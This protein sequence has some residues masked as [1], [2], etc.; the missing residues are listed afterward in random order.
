[1]IHGRLKVSE[2]PNDHGRLRVN[3]LT[4]GMKRGLHRIKKHSCRCMLACC[5]M[6]EP[7]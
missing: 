2:L 3:E 7:M 5:V 1:M 6:N 4:N